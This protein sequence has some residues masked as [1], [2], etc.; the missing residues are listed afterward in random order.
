[1]TTGELIKYFRNKRKMT[2]KALGALCGIADAN[3]RKYENGRQFP[4]WETLEKIAE[5]LQVDTFDLIALAE[6]P[7]LEDLSIIEPDVD[8]LRKEIGDLRYSLNKKGLTKTRD[9]MKSL[10][11]LNDYK[12]NN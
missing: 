10:M 1:M 9:Y 6:E 2:Q 5:A 3:I 12:V 7:D 11:L 4:K 8:E